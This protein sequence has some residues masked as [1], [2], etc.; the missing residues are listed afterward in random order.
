M[1]L[2]TARDERPD[3][4]MAHVEILQAYAATTAIRSLCCINIDTKTTI[5]QC[6]ETSSFVVAEFF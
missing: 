1:V 4:A 5:R 2:G 3:Y 6:V